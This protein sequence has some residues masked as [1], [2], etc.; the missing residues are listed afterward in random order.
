MRRHLPAFTLLV[1]LTS[2]A[3]APSRAIPVKRVAS[4][5]SAPMFVTAPADDDRLFIVERGGT[6]R[7]LENGQVLPAPFLDISDRVD[8][9]GE[10][11]LL[12]LAFPP[13]YAS[14]RAFY[15][16][17]TADGSPP[18]PLTSRI[19]RFRANALDPNQADDAPGD[20]KILLSLDQPETNPHGGTVAFGPDGMLYMGF[21]DGGLRFDP[22]EAAQ[23]PGTLLGKLIRIDVSFGSFGDDYAVPANNPYVGAGEPLDEIW[24]LGLRNPFR[25]SF[26]REGGALYIADVGQDTWEE[27]NVEPPPETKDNQGGRNYGWDVMEGDGCFNEPNDPDELDCNDPKLTLPVHQYDHSGPECSITGGVVYRGAARPD[28]DGLYLFSDW[29]SARI[30]SLRWDGAGGVDG[31]VVDRTD[32]LPPDE[33]ALDN[34]VAFGEDGAGEVYVV[35]QDGDIYQVVP[36]PEPAGA[37]LLGAG[38]AALLAAQRTQSRGT[39]KRSRSSASGEPG[40]GRKS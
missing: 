11:G 34:P 8:Q 23:D 36:V 27:V 9:Q 32:E 19:S 21:G 1:A 28:L 38:A 29:C 35:D 17:Y 4:G 2:L 24:D 10:G 5:L 7:I 25:L 14:S 12:G 31:D 33:G 13:D 6:I 26:D 30:W 22:L 39:R 3:P 16:Y 40:S 18:S 20:E 37:L 15:V